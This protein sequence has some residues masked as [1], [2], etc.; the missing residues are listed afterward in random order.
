MSSHYALSNVRLMCYADFLR[1]LILNCY[2]FLLITKGFMS[3][4]KTLPS[5]IPGSNVITAVGV[6]LF[7]LAM[8]LH[9]CSMSYSGW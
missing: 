9:D 2:I 5:I 3:R 6:G 4:N 7:D 8:I 1:I